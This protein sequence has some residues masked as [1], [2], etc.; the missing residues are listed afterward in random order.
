MFTEGSV[1]L[2]STELEQLILQKS[3][4]KKYVKSDYLFMERQKADQLYLIHSGK[5]R[6]G[7]YTEDG[8]EI[9]FEIAKKGDIIGEAILFSGSNHLTNAFVLEEAVVG[10]VEK[11]EIEEELERQP[12]LSIEYIKWMGEN[13][14]KNQTKIRD[15]ILYGKKE[16]S[17]QH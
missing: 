15:M 11:S 5:I 17:I 1:V 9:T 3:T 14:Q 4:E 8:R 12:K 10:V 16:L 6:I 7:K 13:L 2:I